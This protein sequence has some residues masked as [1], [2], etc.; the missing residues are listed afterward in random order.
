MGANFMLQHVLQHKYNHFKSLYV[1][2]YVYMILYIWMTNM[3]SSTFFIHFPSFS[4]PHIFLSASL[5][6]PS[7]LGGRLHLEPHRQQRLPQRCQWGQQEQQRQ[8]PGAWPPQPALLKGQAQ[9][10]RRHHG[11]Q[12][13]VIHEDQGMNVPAILANYNEIH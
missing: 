3:T 8:G 10:G 2:I 7:H 6:H 12:G 11:G 13:Q 5:S 1:Y 9:Q 4:Y